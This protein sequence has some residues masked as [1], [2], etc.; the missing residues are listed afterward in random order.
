MH[1]NNLWGKVIRNMDQLV[2]GADYVFMYEE[3]D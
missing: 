3:K 1:G 2:G